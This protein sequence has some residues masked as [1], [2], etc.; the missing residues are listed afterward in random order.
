MARMMEKGRSIPSWADGRAGA[1]AKRT[2][3]T[4]ASGS[5]T[6]HPTGGSAKHLATLAGTPPELGLG[7]ARAGCHG[8]A[9]VGCDGVVG[10]CGASPGAGGTVATTAT[11][12]GIAA[13]ATTSTSSVPP[14][15]V[16]PDVVVDVAGAVRQP[17]PVRVAADARVQG[18]I[19]AA[20]GVT[21]DADLDRVDR[22]APLR[23]GERIYVPAVARPRCHR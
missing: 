2:A 19:A 21:A 11:T 10:G 23:D 17:G 7:E 22:A 20:G 1:G 6:A 12:I 3:R 18:A 8:V 9:R 15:T 16:P 5:A 4:G 14:T 13:F